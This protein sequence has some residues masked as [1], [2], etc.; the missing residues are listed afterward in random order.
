VSCDIE[1]ETNELVAVTGLEAAR[2]RWHGQDL[3]CPGG[4]D[5]RADMGPQRS[6]YKRGLGQGSEVGVRQSLESKGR[7]KR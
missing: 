6:Y 1:L 2:S 4:S 3:R 5:A 7:V